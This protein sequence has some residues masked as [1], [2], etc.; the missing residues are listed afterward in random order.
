MRRRS[1]PLSLRAHESYVHHTDAMDLNDHLIFGGDEMRCTC[2]DDHEGSGGKG[3]EARRI[4]GLSEAEMPGALENCDV[5]V[6][7]VGVWLDSEAC[8][9]AYAIRMGT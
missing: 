1:M 4:E 7:G 8:R 9:Q 6:R 5:F 2:W 3:L